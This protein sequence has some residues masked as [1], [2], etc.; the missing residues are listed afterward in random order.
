MEKIAVVTDTGSNL[1]F[2]QAK[3]LGIYLLPLQITIDKT[4]YQD[5]LEISTQ[6][7]YKEL[8]KGKMPKTSMA[9]YQK[10]YNLFEKLKKNTILYLRFH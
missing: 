4:T 10:I 7:I 9:T 1:S 6:D 2:K 8:A 3:E 5:T